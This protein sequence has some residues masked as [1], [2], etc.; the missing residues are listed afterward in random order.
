M[1]SGMHLNKNKY[2]TWEDRL[3]SSN[4]IM[5]RH[6]HVVKWLR[7]NEFRRNETW[8]VYV[9]YFAKFIALA[10][11]AFLSSIWSSLWHECSS[12]SDSK[13]DVYSLQV[14]VN[15]KI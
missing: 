9:S 15:I 11:K 6:V 5:L 8:N 13:E 10:C 3:I 12:T 14:A 4:L 1:T 7:E 2:K